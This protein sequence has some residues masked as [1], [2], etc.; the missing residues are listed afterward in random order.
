MR[1]EYAL[2]EN[3]NNQINM[4]KGKF[5]QRLT[6][7]QRYSNADYWRVAIGGRR[8]RVRAPRGERSQRTRA[9]FPPPPL[10]RLRSR[11][12]LPFL[13]R[14][15]RTRQKA[16][17]SLNHSFDT[18]FYQY[19][20]TATI[21]FESYERKNAQKGRRRQKNLET[22]I[23]VDSGLSMSQ[24]IKRK[25]WNPVAESDIYHICQRHAASYLCLPPRHG[26]LH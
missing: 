22:H 7:W 23:Q 21:S 4:W 6:C 13:W 3:Q 1:D 12:H 9:D 24:D 20:P 8:K 18:P 19:P 10:P 15:N 5:T 25:E 11:R 26:S 2:S 17:V 14:G 16:S